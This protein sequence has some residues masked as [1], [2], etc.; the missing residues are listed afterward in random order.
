MAESYSAL[1]GHKKMLPLK[2]A[3]VRASQAHTTEAKP[4]CSHLGY[5]S[6]SMVL[7]TSVNSP[8]PPLPLEKLYIGEGKWWG[9]EER[10]ADKK[11]QP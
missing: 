9:E 5:N 2:P 3:A 11:H 7:P 6:T 4:P 1:Y 10:K 8:L